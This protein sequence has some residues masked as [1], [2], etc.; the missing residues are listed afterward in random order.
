[1][2]KD[3]VSL[4]YKYNVVT[5]EPIREGVGKLKFAYNVDNGVHF[6]PTFVEDYITRD[7]GKKLFYNILNACRNFEDSKWEE[8]MID[9]PGITVFAKEQIREHLERMKGNEMREM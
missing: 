9:N 2:N 6:L 5:Y 1:L 3:Y 8:S 4:I 7:F